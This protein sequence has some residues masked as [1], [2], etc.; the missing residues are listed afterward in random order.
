M[1]ELAKSG[2]LFAAP[3]FDQTPPELRRIND[4]A[5]SGDGEPTSFKGFAE[6]CRIAAEL[7]PTGGVGPAEVA[8]S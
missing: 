4:V 5:F 1:L 7:R 6:S 3:P 2:E 8:G